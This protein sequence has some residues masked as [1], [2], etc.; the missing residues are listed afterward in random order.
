MEKIKPT[1]FICPICKGNGY[2]T[3]A[4]DAATPYLKVEIDCEACNSQGEILKNEKNIFALRLSL[5]HI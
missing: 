3:I 4:K 2:R 1:K 5:I